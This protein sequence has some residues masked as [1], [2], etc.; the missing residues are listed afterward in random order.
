MGC[1]SVC[2]SVCLSVTFTHN[3][4]IF[5]PRSFKFC[6]VVDI[7]VTKK[8]IKKKLTIMMMIMMMK[9][10]IAVFAFLAITHPKIIFLGL[11]P[12]NELFLCKNTTFLLKKIFFFFEIQ[13]FKFFLFF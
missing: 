2:W 5:A 4:V 13:N 6:V 10:I 12:K 3:S 1:L 7:E 8:F 11:K 9:M